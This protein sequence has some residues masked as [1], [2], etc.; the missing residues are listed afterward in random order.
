VF[1][2]YSHT[3]TA[4]GKQYVG[5]TKLTMEAR[6]RQHVKEAR[7]GRGHYLHAAIR[8][9]GADTFT[10]EVLDVVLTR[11]G[12]DVA[13]RAWITHRNCRAPHGYNLE[14]G[15]TCGKEIH[16]ETRNRIGDKSRQRWAAM[17]PDERVALSRSMTASITPAQRSAAMRAWNARR[18]PEER[19]AGGAKA[20]QT[21]SPGQRS[22]RGRKAAA[23]IMASPERLAIRIRKFQETIAATSTHEERSQRVRDSWA[24]IPPDQRRDIVA[25]RAATRRANRTPEELRALARIGGA[26]SKAARQ[27]WSNEQIEQDRARRTARFQTYLANTTT[28]ERSAAAKARE[29][30][31]TPE[32]R[33]ANTANG[34]EAMRRLLAAG[35]I[36]VGR[37]FTVVIDLDAAR[38]LL[39][40]G[41]TLV[42]VARQLGVVETTLR[43]RLRSAR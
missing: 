6:W 9:Y 18:T 14:A 36:R 42:A 11:A 27:S 17:T 2:I 39:N 35:L 29:A 23:T 28:E 32:Q 8:K 3:C 10:H 21:Q 43:R 41:M 30:A 26:A 5:Q 7:I 38:A 25:A 22:H 13:E 24:A 4:T 19:S 33:R 1:I 12:A 31:Y 20:A 15:G 37:P 34:R 40:T 16:T